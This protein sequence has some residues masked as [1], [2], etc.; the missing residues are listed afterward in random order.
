MDSYARRH[1]HPAPPPFR[2]PPQF[3]ALG[4]SSC[5]DASWSAFCRSV[6]PTEPRAAL[7]VGARVVITGLV[8]S[9][10]YN[11]QAGVIVGGLDS[12]NDSSY[13]VR[14]DDADGA[15]VNLRPANITAADQF[16]ESPSIMQCSCAHT[17]QDYVGRCQRSPSPPSPPPRDRSRASP[18]ACPPPPPPLS[19]VLVLL[20]ET[21]EVTRR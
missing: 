17:V 15:E 7:A 16:C 12:K 2:C 19:R 11:G 3:K 9:Q 14:L 5:T 6:L 8:T 1:H 21:K 10:E 20:F 4:S 18:P 13:G